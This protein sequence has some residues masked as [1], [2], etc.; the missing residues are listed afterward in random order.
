MYPRGVR[1]V[2][3][4]PRSAPRP[5]G[6][7]A[8]HALFRAI[9]KGLPSGWA[10]WH[11]L[12]LRIDGSMEGEG[13]FVFAIPD[14]GVL[15]LEVK[16]GAIQCVDGHWLQNGQRLAKAPRDQGLR[17]ARMLRERLERDVG[18]PPWCAA[19]VTFPD[20][21]V[22]DGPSHDDLRGIVL[23]HED[24]AY[25][26]DA[27]TSIVERLFKRDG[28]KI[29]APRNPTWIERLHEYWGE[30]WTPRLTLRDEKERRDEEMVAWDDFQLTLLSAIE[31]N[32]RFLVTGGPGTGKTLVARE[33]IGRLTAR[34][35]RVLYLCWTRALANGLRAEGLAH[36]W[37][38]R[39]YAAHLLREADR[40][41]EP[42]VP[43]TS[44]KPETWDDVSLHAAIEA[45]PHVPPWDALVVDE[46][47]DLT[48]ND[49]ELV[50]TLAGD[51][52]LWAFGD[53]GQ[54]Y[55]PERT[56]PDELRTHSF[57]LPKRYRC[58]EALS[59]F[60]DLYRASRPH[61]AP[62]PPPGAFPELR[63]VRAPSASNVAAKVG[64]EIEKALGGGL[65]PSDIAVLS[66]AGQTRTELANAERIG[67]TSVVRADDPRAHVSV[68]CDTFLRFKGLERALV[69]V[70]ELGEK[71]RRQH[72]TRMH[73]ALTR[74]TMRCVVVATGA[75]LAADPRLAARE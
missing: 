21:R 70:S 55:W 38:V 65:R 27:L 37:A 51:R 60:A 41:I 11:S 48:S 71:P 31:H 24:L 13:D 19:A 14:R 66:L 4:Y 72:D 7:H 33:L 61:G 69:I 25:V 36:A 8:E 5:T 12:R 10:A 26:G 54:S 49:W 46:A 62:E 42:G 29:V 59:C 20:V 47:Q 16:G 17:F 9:H 32:P 15:V 73:I 22:E 23:G 45:A 28:Q 52:I 75:E 18:Y 44:W 57:K 40:E 30:T 63:I 67:T 64:L 35:M 58:P 34:G 39:E 53:D 56:W 74:A 2:G 3:L 68:V 43:S 1:P 6:S 50:R